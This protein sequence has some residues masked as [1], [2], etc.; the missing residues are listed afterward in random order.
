MTNLYRKSEITFAVLWIIAY[1]ILSSYAD[2][3][4]LN[5]GTVKSVTAVLHIAMTLIL[6]CWI[7]RNDL[8]RKY[9]LVMPQIP[10]RRFLYYIP[11]VLIAA[12]TFIEGAA[13][14]YSAAG[15]VCYVVSMICVGFLEE[16]LFRGFLFRA[17]EK[18]GLKSAVIVS[19]LTFGIG[20]IV[21]LFNGSGKMMADSIVQIVFAVMVGLALVLIFYYGGSLVPCIVFHS[22]N[23]ALKAFEAEG[24]MD[25]R[26]AMALNF[27]LIFFVLGGYIIYLYKAFHQNV[28]E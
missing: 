13:M 8:S 5:L 3:I 17:M 15:T 7:R 11:L 4:S 18:D 28:T 26:L 2:R 25:P 19:S 6:Y 12:V 9:G 21:N 1:V 24:T 16:I 27:V 10:A 20:H 23:N 22:A 14:N